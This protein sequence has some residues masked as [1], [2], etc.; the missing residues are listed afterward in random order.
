MLMIRKW[1]DLPGTQEGQT[2]SDARI[3]FLAR[4]EVTAQKAEMNSKKFYNL[5]DNKV[6]RMDRMNQA[7]GTIFSR[8]MVTKKEEDILVGLK[9]YRITKVEQMEA[10]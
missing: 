5:C 6:H 2:M 8:N 7:K 1:L 9:T 10:F 4:D 3:L